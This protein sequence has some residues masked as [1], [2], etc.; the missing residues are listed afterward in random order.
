[1][2]SLRNLTTDD[3]LAKRYCDTKDKGLDA[4]AKEL[5][6]SFKVEYVPSKLSPDNIH[7]Y[8][9]K[10]TEG[11]VNLKDPEHVRYLQQFCSAFISHC[12]AL[13][14]KAL[15]KEKESPP[16]SDGLYLE[17][18]NHAE[19]CLAK[20]KSFCG[21]KDILGD[22]FASLKKEEVSNKPLVVHGVSG[23]GKTS[24]MAMIAKNAC[25]ELGEKYV[26]ITRFLGTTPES[27]SI[28][29]VIQSICRQIIAAYNL[30]VKM[31]DVFNQ[32]TE[33]VD[34]FKLLLKMVSD[35]CKGRPLLILLDSLDQLANTHNA[36]QCR[37]LVRV[38][39]PN[40]RMVL[41][42][43]PELHGILDNLRKIV[44]DEG[45]FFPVK[46][47]PED[48]MDEIL[49]SWMAGI[50]RKVTDQQRQCIQKG[51]GCLN[52]GGGFAGL[53]Y[54]NTATTEFSN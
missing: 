13:I 20:C 30:D 14:Q 18:A 48:T 22:I 41:S 37:W 51:K 33:L 7:Y 32:F 45:C 8:D 10:W 23:S 1:M 9:I 40:V 26:V 46:A 19:F 6:D 38:C 47:L 29:M 31:A 54:N 16:I 4:E 15:D 25:E 11:G 53:L 43:L 34:F 36:F 35:D 2:R 44:V 39:P 12:K 27:S 52:M 42:T 3:P 17:A 50:N 21:R 5:L 49:D 24:I 28:A